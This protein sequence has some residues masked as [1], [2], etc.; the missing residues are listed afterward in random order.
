MQDLAVKQRDYQS[1][2]LASEAEAAGPAG[3]SSAK[4][5]GDTEKTAEQTGELVAAEDNP[6]CKGQEI[7]HQLSQQLISATTSLN[8]LAQKNLQARGWLGAAP[9]PS[10]TSTNG[11][12]AQ[13]GNLLLSRILYQLCQR[14]EAALPPGEEPGRADRRPAL[15]S[16]AE[17]HA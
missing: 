9:R 4:R 12:D 8:S 15:A 16:S 13:K 14:L 10:A 3:Q 2:R 1:A 5:L 17:Q 6:W 11:A 7:N